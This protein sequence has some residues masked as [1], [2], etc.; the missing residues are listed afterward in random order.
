MPESSEIQPVAPQPA[1]PAGPQITLVLP[2]DVDHDNQL[3]FK[4]NQDMWVIGPHGGGHLGGEW[5][6]EGKTV[7]TGWAIL[8]VVVVGYLAA[9]STWSWQGLLVGAVVFA[10]GWWLS[11]IVRR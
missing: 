6:R 2:A 8:G 5:E 10:Y 3:D 11:K 9:T 4:R 7:V 1:P